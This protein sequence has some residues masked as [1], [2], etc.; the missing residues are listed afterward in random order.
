VLEHCRQ[1]GRKAEAIFLEPQARNTAPALALVA[2][3]M[4]SQ[5]RNEPLLVLPADHRITD[6]D[7]FKSALAKAELHAKTG[8]LVTLGVE[9][10]EPHTGY[11]YIRRGGRVGTGYRIDSFQ[12]KPDRE[13]AE[14]YLASGDYFWNSGIFLFQPEAYLNELRQNQPGIVVACHEALAG[15]YSDLDFLRIDGAAYERSLSKSIDY[16]V[17]E[18]TRKG[19]VIPVACGWSDIGSWTSLHASNPSDDQMNVVKG[20]A[21][22]H[23]CRNSYVQS[24]GR[25]IAAIGV[26][27]LIIVD[28]HDALMVAAADHVQDVGKVAASVIDSGDRSVSEKGQSVFRP[29]GHYTT[30]STGDDFCIRKLEILPGASLSDHSHDFRSECWVVLKGRARVTTETGTVE[31]VSGESMNINRTI[32]HKLENGGSGTLEIIETQTGLG[33][34]EEDISRKPS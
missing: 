26:E 34:S 31:L 5:G 19:V 22:L 16:A 14:S 25:T 18:H 23:N 13:T 8:A 12:E 17:M 33:I 15:K 6:T 1:V 30:L 20:K 3:D 2:L 21:V 27:N 4:V 32:Q 11:G 29:W 24:S 9:A 10:E 28:S 7:A